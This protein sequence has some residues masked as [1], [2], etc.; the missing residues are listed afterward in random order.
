MEQN[1]L[2]LTGVVMHQSPVRTS[3]AGVPHQDWRLEHRSRQQQVGR[4]REAR[5]SLGVHLA[6]ELVGQSQGVKPGD[7]VRVT[8]F[9]AQASHRDSEQVVLHA[10]TIERQD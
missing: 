3:P 7:R 2:N 9:L 8:G 4:M 5:L 6:G 10:L 1:T